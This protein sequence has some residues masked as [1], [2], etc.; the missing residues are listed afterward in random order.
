MT[1][2]PEL[3]NHR[4]MESTQYVTAK[5]SKIKGSWDNMLTELKKH[6]AIEPNANAKFTPPKENELLSS[7][8]NRL[9]RYRGET[10]KIVKKGHPEKLELP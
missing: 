1:F 9:N 6:F 5:A 8:E 3:E 4:I 10:T 7:I 2:V